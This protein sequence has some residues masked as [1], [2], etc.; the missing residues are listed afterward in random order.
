MFKGSK[1]IIGKKIGEKN[2]KKN[3]QI[4]WYQRFLVNLADF[5]IFWGGVGGITSSSSSTLDT[6]VLVDRVLRRGGEEGDVFS[7]S[8]PD[9]TVLVD[10]VLRRGGGVG[11]SSTLDTTALVA[12]F[13]RWGGEGDV[14]SSST[15]ETTVLVDCVLRRGGEGDVCSSSTAGAL[16]W[17]CF[18]VLDG[19]AFSLFVVELNVHKI[20][21]K[22]NG[23]QKIYWTICINYLNK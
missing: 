6:S 1:R 14:C 11:S 22:F 23:L 7:S 20:Q 8:T 4:C 2:C 13:L 10:R 18:R 19:L 15:L 9:T 3:K 16:R 17:A 5:V 21:W 12:R